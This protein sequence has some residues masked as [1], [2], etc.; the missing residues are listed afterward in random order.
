MNR[1]GWTFPQHAY[2]VAKAAER[3]RDHHQSRLDWW[4]SKLAELMEQI[5][6]QGLEIEE[7]LAMQYSRASL[8]GSMKGGNRARIVVRDDYQ[9]KLDE[10]Q[11]KIQEHNQKAVEYD[12][13]FKV[14]SANQG[15]VV[16][17]DADDYT[18]FFVDGKPGADAAE[19]C[20][21]F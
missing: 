2:N 8:V 21:L 1:K 16:E 6:S 3:K 4:K 19:P 10:C 15:Q 5:K 20:Q 12:S 18:F 13:W 7:P 17:L 14:L 9:R 11:I